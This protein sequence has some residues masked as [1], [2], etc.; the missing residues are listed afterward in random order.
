MLRHRPTSL[1]V[2]TAAGAVVVAATFLPWLRAGATSRSSY[3]L[4][5]MIDRLDL[6]PGGMVSTAIRYWP[7]VP[8]LVTAA[9]VGAWWGAQWWAFA[10]AC[11][12]ALYAGGVG[13]ALLLTARD[14]GVSVGPGPWICTAACLV[15]VG[16]AAWA[17]LTH[18]T[19]R[20]LRTPPGAPPVD[21]S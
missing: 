17:T 7:V 13:V 4:L 6:A 9:V 2:V 12:A 3:D 19:G 14:V 8:L 1:L 20:G 10:A 18:A 11:V 21:P 5:G 16:G 15:F